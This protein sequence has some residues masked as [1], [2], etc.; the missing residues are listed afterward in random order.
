MVDGV[1]NLLGIGD[2]EESSTPS[3][4]PSASAP[5][6]A[7][8]EPSTTTTTTAPAGDDATPSTSVAPSK[9]TA[10]SAASADDDIIPCLGARQR[11]KVAD[12]GGIPR[13]AIKPGVMKVGSLTMINSTY[14]GVADVPTANGVIKSLQFNMKQ[15][16]NEPFSLTIA[17]PNGGTTT[18]KSAKLTT[19]DNVKFYTPKFTGNLF[20]VIPV[21]FTP[22][23]PPP[24]TL[25]ILWFTNVTID[26]AF[27]SCDTLTAD[28]LQI[29]ES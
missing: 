21:T 23:Q 3:A 20:G 27:V 11:G 24:L 2:D 9:P 10:S 14:E 25:P 1:S 16:I 5:S 15:A 4:S 28:P 19:T 26:L 7:A 22:A 8:A 18:V 13:S 6:S 17:E 12:D 29:T